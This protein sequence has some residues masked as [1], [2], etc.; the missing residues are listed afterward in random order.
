MKFR[1]TLSISKIK[2]IWEG[3]P[4]YGSVFKQRSN[5][6]FER[7]DE[8]GGIVWWNIWIKEPTFAFPTDYVMHAPFEF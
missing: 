7:S 4:N 2:L 8:A 5:I 1:W 3:G 6:C